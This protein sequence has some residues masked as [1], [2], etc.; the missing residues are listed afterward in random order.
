MPKLSL[1]RTTT[2]TGKHTCSHTERKRRHRVPRGGS[3]APGSKLLN[4]RGQTSSTGRTARRA[5]TQTGALAWCVP[6]RSAL[7]VMSQEAQPEEDKDSKHRWGG[8]S[9]LPNVSRLLVARRLRAVSKPRTEGV[10]TSLSPLGGRLQGVQ[11][12]SLCGRPPTLVL[13]LRRSRASVPDRCDSIDAQQRTT[14]ESGEQGGSPCK[15]DSTDSSGAGYAAPARVAP[16]RGVRWD[17]M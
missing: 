9:P 8:S 5:D 16:A 2:H 4:K 13:E 10:R 3:G 14:K 17:A 1:T 11:T 7:S 6:C 15:L 12:A